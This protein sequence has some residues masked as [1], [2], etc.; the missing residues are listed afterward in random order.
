MTNVPLRYY[1]NGDL[2]ATIIDPRF[3]IG[4]EPTAPDGWGGTGGGSGGAVDAGHLMNVTGNVTLP[5]E[6]IV[7][8]LAGYRVTTGTATFTDGTLTVTLGQGGYIFE[9]TDTGWTYLALP[10][11]ARMGGAPTPGN[12]SIAGV[13]DKSIAVWVGGAYDDIALHATPYRFSSDGGSTWSSWQ[14]APGHHHTARTAN[15]AY[16]LRHEVRDAAENTTQGVIVPATTTTAGQTLGA[17]TI[18]AG[19]TATGDNLTLTGSAEATAHR[20]ATS[21]A[22]ASVRAVVSSWRTG[23]SNALSGPILRWVDSNN[24]LYYTFGSGVANAASL[25]RVVAG[26][27][28][29][30]ASW[31][32][33]I[34]TNNLHVPFV[35]RVDID[36]NNFTCYDRDGITPFGTATVTEHSASTTVGLRKGGLASAAGGATPWSI[37]VY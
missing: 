36:G 6:A 1:E 37:T 13:T 7:G 15:T 27:D 20:T 9:H 21:L 12:L 31:T 5:E 24:Y 22:D 8:D 17:W 25:R 34:D 16:D 26:T 19:F 32:P 35:A 30:V 33:T 3:G 10:A 11:P 14:A 28:T 29:L 2:L 4:D 18:V 23:G